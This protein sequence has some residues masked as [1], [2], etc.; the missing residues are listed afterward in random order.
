MPELAISKLAAGHFDRT[1]SVK[2]DSKA[3]LARLAFSF[4]IIA[5]VLVWQAYQLRRTALPSE[6]WRVWLY[7]VA[8]GLSA[9]L[10]A[11]GIRARHHDDRPGHG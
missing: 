3:W 9:A 10:G 8:A 6:Q 11:A 5:A 2:L 7:L 4:L 1:L